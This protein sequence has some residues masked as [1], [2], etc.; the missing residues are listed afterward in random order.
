MYVLII[1][2]LGNLAPH[3]AFDAC[4]REPIV[5]KLFGVKVGEPH[6]QQ[7]SNPQPL[8]QESS[9]LSTELRGL[10]KYSTFLIYSSG[11]FDNEVIYILQDLFCIAVCSVETVNL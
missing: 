6:P 2:T 3:L 9:A 10:T 5:T 11:Q 1:S 7:D 8:D 4:G